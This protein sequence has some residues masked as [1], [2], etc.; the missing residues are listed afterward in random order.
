MRKSFIN[1]FLVFIFFT[2]P[3]YSQ[4]SSQY[5]NFGLFPTPF[6][7]NSLSSYV[8]PNSGKD[9]FNTDFM[10]GFGTL[11][12]QNIYSFSL[13]FPTVIGNFIFGFSYLDSP[14]S[15]NIGYLAYNKEVAEDLYF[16]L[17]FKSGVVSGNFVFGLDFGTNY[18]IDNTT[19]VSFIVKNIG[20][21]KVDDNTFFPIGLRL[22]IK[23]D[24]SFINEGKT[25]IFGGIFSSFYSFGNTVT[26]GVLQ[27]I[28]FLKAGFG[29]GFDINSDNYNSLGPVF[30]NIGLS[31]VFKNFSISGNY[32]IYPFS[33]FEDKKDAKHIFDIS[34]GF[35][36]EDKKPPVVNIEFYT[37]LE[38]DNIIYI[39][40]NS[41]GVNDELT[42]GLEIDDESMVQEWK[43]IV[44]DSSGNVVY[45]R[46]DVI[47]KDKPSFKSFGNI[48]TSKKSA[49]YPSTIIWPAIDNNGNKLPDGMYTFEIY[50]KDF[51]G[52]YVSYGNQYTKSVQ[53]VVIDTIPPGLKIGLPY[54]SFSPNGDGIK[55][56][57]TINHIGP[58]NNTL[59]TITIKSGNQVVYKKFYEDL[60]E[61]FVWDGKN[62]D[63]KALPDGEY[64]YVVD[65]V[66][67]AGN[68]YTVS[69]KI[70]IDTK[71]P[72][73]IA[74]V[75]DNYFS[76]NGDGIKDFIVVEQKID[77]KGNWQGIIKDEKDNIVYSK[78]WKGN[79]PSNFKWDGRDN[80][81]NIVP[82]GKYTY[83]IE[84]E[85]E[86]GNRLSQKI[87]TFIVDNT[88]PKSE[89]E[90]VNTIFSPNDDG[91]ND[92]LGIIMKNSTN[93]DYWIL[94]IL[95]DKTVIQSF[96]WD[97]APP[98][99]LV[100]NGKVNN[101][102]LPDGKYTVILRS[103]D[104]AGNKFI[105]Q[106]EFIVDN[107]PPFLEIFLKDKIFS[108]NNDNIKD[109]LDVNIKTDADFLSFVVIDNNGEVV[110]QKNLE[111][112]I[113]SFVWDG[114]GLNDGDYRII[115]EAKDKA[116]NTSIKSDVVKIL[117]IDQPIELTAD[118]NIINP[119]NDKYNTV[120]FISNI[121]KK[122]Y[123]EKI[124]FSIKYNN[125]E[126]YKKTYNDNKIVFKGVTDDG[127]LKDG[128]Y[129][130][131]ITVYYKNGDRLKSNEVSF[132]IDT[133]GPVVKM[134]VYPDLFS[135]DD[136]GENDILYIDLDA[137]DV[138]GIKEWKIVIEDR[139]KEPF[140]IFKGTKPSVV[141]WNGISDDGELT[142]S[143]EDY[144]VYAE[145]IDNVGNV[146]V[147]DRIPFTVDILVIKTARGY[148]IRISNIEFDLNKADLKTS[149]FPILNKLA[150]KLA[151]F[152][153]YKIKIEGH[154]D[155]TGREEWNEK[156]SLMRANSVK[157]YLVNVKKLQS[158]MFYTEG[159]GSRIPLFP[160]D[161][162]KNRAKN[163]R[164]EFLLI[165][166]K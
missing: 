31:K 133:K 23:K 134:N 144:N 71:L 70:V 129:N 116:G 62:E 124:E 149:A 106:R 164:V 13:G 118:R 21:S 113:R 54:N 89:L 120:N 112:S 85:D 130:A 17:S 138:S 98:K 57:I 28:Y 82:D 142:A 66:D 162:P 56:N 125:D 67:K 122:D 15:V 35:G 10:L 131:D 81:N 87:S 19:E 30:G 73:L 5:Y 156:L 135:P 4:N 25:T 84:G 91:N 166:Q 83:Y 63:G 58:S 29:F 128:K 32:Y 159:F 97:N 139:F 157:D 114:D 161:T 65:G 90:L 14:Q 43:F 132:V 150:E 46:G 79:I 37:L 39:S 126:I 101:T 108:P 38:K 69:E 45:E 140:K 75:G 72:T 160:N 36:G 18:I 55:D 6:F 153:D 100:W 22:D 86:S 102:V 99:S 127:I 136:D 2:L 110:S 115:F 111:P 47:T 165:K 3:C 109:T 77:K 147:T 163:R 59:W 74:S 64:F 103:E 137:K 20:L 104:R 76:P 60:P 68:R 105:T 50:A 88:P 117:R 96:Y 8:S 51:K 49:L 80:N 141:M 93:E 52:N 26:L 1:I 148:Q 123:V 40:P 27:N 158:S 94:E 95:K 53:K 44:K 155:S 121:P 7:K 24:F 34:V 146:T 145:V 78:A 151:K 9:I 143:A 119:L 154:A 61:K 42:F 41:D 33:K 11:T 92:N 12:D 152:P 48:F 107:T 16:G